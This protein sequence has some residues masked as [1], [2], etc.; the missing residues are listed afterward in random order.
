MKKINLEKTEIQCIINFLNE[1]FN[2]Q[3]VFKL[4]SRYNYYYIDMYN[5]DE[6]LIKSGVCFGESIKKLLSDLHT[7]QTAC[8]IS[9]NFNNNLFKK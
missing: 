4:T 9:F 6:Q 1:L 2:N 7:F 8:T 5:C 3:K